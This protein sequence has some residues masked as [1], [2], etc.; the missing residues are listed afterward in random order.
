LKVYFITA[1]MEEL[2]SEELRHIAEHALH[3]L[4]E[5]NLQV[6]A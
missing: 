6:S 2:V 5:V 4:R 3:N 1:K